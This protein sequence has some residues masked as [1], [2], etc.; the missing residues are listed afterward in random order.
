MNQLFFQDTLYVLLQST[1]RLYI[2]CVVLNYEQI[3]KSKTMDIRIKQARS[4]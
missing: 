2:A 1:S 4:H 3:R